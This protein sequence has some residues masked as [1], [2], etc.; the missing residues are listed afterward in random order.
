MPDYI[1]NNEKKEVR[2]RIY[3]KMIDEKYV[4]LLKQIPELSLNECIALD[5]VQKHK[6][7]LPEI[8]KALK[9]KGYIEKIKSE[10]F[11]SEYIARETRQLP[12]Y[13]KRKGLGR[14]YYKD[15]VIELLSK[16]RKG[17]T[18]KDIDSLLLDMVPKFSKNP[19]SY[20]GNLLSEMKDKDHSIYLNNNRWK[21]DGK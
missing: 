8:A 13:V 20:I 15:M 9:A 18:R 19:S 21:I 4:E 7:I 6:P 11:I 2:V 1:I 3:G 14:K 5:C 17:L 10:W 16:N 12:D